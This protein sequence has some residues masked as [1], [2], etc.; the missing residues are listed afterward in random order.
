MQDFF[1][2][3]FAKIYFH[4]VMTEVRQNHFRK[5]QFKLQP[6]DLSQQQ[7]N[8]N[9]KRKNCTYWSIKDIFSSILNWSAEHFCHPKNALVTQKL[10]LFSE[11]FIY[12]Y[13]YIYIYIQSISISMHIQSGLQFLLNYKEVRFF[14]RSSKLG[15]I[16]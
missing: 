11:Y 13:I 2:G 1:G 16:F 6:Q 10:Q 5:K 7:E 9:I 12:I 4:Q 15:S 3:Q 8:R 14:P